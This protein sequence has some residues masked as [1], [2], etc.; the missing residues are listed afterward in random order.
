MLTASATARALSD[1]IGGN[2][3]GKVVDGEPRIVV[4]SRQPGALAEA[5]VVLPVEGDGRMGL[6][7][8]C[9]RG[10]IPDF[11]PKTQEVGQL[12]AGKLIL[13]QAGHNGKESE[14][15]VDEGPQD[16]IMLGGHRG[17]VVPRPTQ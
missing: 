6:F 7:K 10:R 14:E 11:Q 8:A 15:S 17:A 13:G 3:W 12:G 4:E 16:A 9:S 5:L 1:V 2:P